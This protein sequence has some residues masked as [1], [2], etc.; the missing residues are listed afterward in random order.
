MYSDYHVHSLF[1]FD[2][3][4]NLE[5]IFEKAVS[6]NME[7]IAITDHQDFNWPIEGE[8]PYVNMEK[9]DDMI[10]FYQE[11]YKNKITILKGIE[12]GLMKGNSTLCQNLINTFMFDFVIGSC[13]IV[14]NMD[15]YYSDFWKNRDDRASFE[16]YFKTLLDGLK[17]FNQIDTLGHLDYIVRYSPNKDTNYSV[18]DYLDVIDEILKF[19]IQRD[20]KL[21]INTANLAKG[22]CFPNPHTDII[23]RYRELGGQY[24]TVGSDAHSAL[25]IGYEFD[26]AEEI[27]K[28]FQLKIYEK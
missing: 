3:E 17:D 15:P 1:S 19:I 28:K 25:Q 21:E 5:N 22:F 4:E 26:K 10:S 27:I 23:N 8:C 14:D 12:L 2:S 24:V 6:L 11:K 16:L 9:Y 20:I 7:Q 18:F 13:H